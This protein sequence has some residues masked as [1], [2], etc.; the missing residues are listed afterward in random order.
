MTRTGWTRWENAQLIAQGVLEIGDGYRAKNSE[1]GPAGLPFA[2]A[3]NI[4]NGFHLQDADL[5]QPGS[6]HLAREKI[7]RPGDIVLT[8]KGTVGRFAFVKQNTP[9]FVYSPQLCYWRIKRPS[10]IDPRY[11]FYWMQGKEFLT[12]VHQVKSQTTIADYVS[13][14]DQRRMYI[15]APPL[16]IQRTIAGILSAYDDLIDNNTRRIANLEERARLL[17]DE[18]FVKFRFPGHERVRLV[19]SAAGMAPEGWEVVKLGE[20]AG[21]NLKSIKSGSEPEEICYV[22]IRSVSTGTI[23]KIDLLPFRTAPSRARR[24]VKHG[25]II[26]STVR[27]N[28]KSYSLILHPPETMVVSTGF[29]VISALQVPFTYLYLAT[30]TDDFVIYLTNR[31]TGTAYL[32]V[33]PRD[34]Q[35]ALIVL[36]P[37]ELLAAFDAQTVH[38]FELRESLYRRTAILRQTRERLLPGLV[39]GEIDVAGWRAGEAREMASVLARHVAEAAGPVEPVGDEGMAWDSLWE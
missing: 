19:E 22:D 24:L 39:A 6:V 15:L 33:N 34:F 26:W 25:D 31:A 12:Q 28:L 18:W 35:Q 1:L 7:S 11:L 16:P 23:E 29:A 3:G 14:G 8:S 17:Y 10:L 30:T 9:K 38:L 32:A 36:P 20:I 27:P 4:Q 5:L 21:V 37:Q 2:R 13:L